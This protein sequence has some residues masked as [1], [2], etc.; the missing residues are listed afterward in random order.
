MHPYLE[1]L[2]TL[3]QA[4][5]QKADQAPPVP[6]KRRPVS[7][8]APVVLICSPH[9]DDECIIGALPYRLRREN[10]WRVV[11]L[12]VTLGSKLARQEERLQ[13]LRG[14][15][16]YLEFEL[17]VA[18]GTGFNKVYLE[19]RRNQPDLWL[20]MTGWLAACLMQLRPSLIVFPHNMDYN[21]THLGTNLLVRH[22][23]WRTRAALS[24]WCLETEFWAAMDHPNLMVESTSE[25]VAELMGALSL[26][27]GE[28]ERNPYHWRLPAWMMDNVRRGS[29]LLAGAG[30]PAKPFPFATLYHLAR[31]HDGKYQ[32]ALPDP[33]FIS[34]KE[35][36]A[37]LLTH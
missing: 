12:A 32:N 7:A 14:A 15:C 3:E 26:H 28:V 37:D 23:L 10:G 5:A 17:L 13:E 25:D 9:P 18:G 8:D 11:N 22:A 31:W 35:S 27:R 29:E 21:P 16:N 36:A 24:C 4:T 30:S 33:L 19:T 34:Q 2:K 1:F 6:R 20:E